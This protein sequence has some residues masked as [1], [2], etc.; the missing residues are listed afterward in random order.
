MQLL[1]L[2]G[3]GL[4]LA[5]TAAAQITTIGPFTGDHSE[6]FETQP[7]NPPTVQCI[8]N[9]V[10]N[11][12][13]DLCAANG[14][15]TMLITSSWSFMCVIFP[16]TGGRLFG[17]TGD[18]A[19]FTFDADVNRF[20]GYFGTNAWAAGN[21][22]NQTV[23]VQF[24]DRNGNSLGSQLANVTADCQ[25]NWNGWASTTGIASIL[26]TNSAFGG[27]FVNLDSL[28]VSV[29]G[30]GTVGTNYCTANANSTGQTGLLTGTGSASVALNNL[31]LEASRLPLNTFGLFLTSL[32]Q[33]TIQN[34][35]GSQGV[36]CLG[37]NIGRYTGPG[38]IKNSGAM[39]K[40]ELL[41]NLT[42]IPSPTGFVSAMVGQTR[43]FQAWHRDSVG[44]SVT[45]NFT[46]GVAVLFN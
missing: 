34:P 26:V 23:T 6:S 3:L 7:T 42:Q 43:S 8:A 25:Y 35:G 22:T 24:F 45:S 36:L 20:G 39:G 18:P 44:G 1:K 31:T 2:T 13:A 28:E 38:Q 46:N 37:G 40:F 12:T 14:N 32:T 5:A 10:F 33:G 41:L 17:S 4:C 29:G 19:L 21:P 30:G 15:S 9:R 11:G 27:G 16:H